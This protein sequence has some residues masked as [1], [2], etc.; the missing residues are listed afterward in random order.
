MTQDS[1]HHL[2]ATKDKMSTLKLRKGLNKV[3]EMVEL[4]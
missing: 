1:V 4:V 3:K 2:F